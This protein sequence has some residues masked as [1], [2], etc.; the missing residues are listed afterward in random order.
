MK[1]KK[2]HAHALGNYALH[3][4]PVVHESSLKKDNL[5]KLSSVAQKI[6]LKNTSENEYKNMKKCN[7]VPFSTGVSVFSHDETGH[8]F[9]GNLV[10]CGNV[11]L[12]AV[13]ARKIHAKR[14][15]EISKALAWVYRNGYKVVMV[16]YTQPHQRCDSL[17]DIVSKYKVASNIL[18]TGKRYNKFRKKHG[19]LG[20]IRGLEVTYGRRN[21][22]HWHTHSLLIVKADADIKAMRQELTEKWFNSCQSAGFDIPDK[23]YFFEYAVDVIDNCKSSDYLAKMGR[24]WGADRELVGGAVKSGKCGN[25]TPFDLLAN[26]EEALFLEYAMAVKGMSQIR[27]SRGLKK[28]V[29]IVHKTDEKLV[30]EQEENAVTVA[31]VPLPT[32]RFILKQELRAL[33]LVI[34][35]QYGYAGLCQYFS[36]YGYKVQPP[37]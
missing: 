33:V 35:E 12:C 5:Y 8:A 22:W 20:E 19:F 31:V 27:W 10:Q 3:K 23:N 15:K 32:W 36:E 18:K 4:S 34:A 26:G 30:Y 16:T 14:A 1:K 11:W 21:G 6:M 29:G 37:E 7:K 17:G 2:N 13:C 9:Y 25:M 24:S 28:L